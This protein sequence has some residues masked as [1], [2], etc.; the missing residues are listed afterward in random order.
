MPAQP[1]LM[2]LGGLAALLGLVYLPLGRLA[3]YLAWPWIVYTI[4]VLEALAQAP[5]ARR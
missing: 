5:V 4:R 1:P 2:V 3:A